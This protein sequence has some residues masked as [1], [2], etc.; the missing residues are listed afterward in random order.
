MALRQV[1]GTEDHRFHI[2]FPNTAA[3][4]TEARY[5]MVGF[6]RA[7]RLPPEFVADVEVVVGEALANAA[8]HGYRARGT[9]IIDAKLT[10]QYLEAT[11][12]DDGPGFFHRGPRPLQHPPAYSPRGYGTF[13]M[14]ALADQLEFRNDG[15]TV[16]FRM[17]VRSNA[18]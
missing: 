16:W 11:V 6:I 8:E 4:T 15:R 9:I 18:E 17:R 5:Q 3:G 2:A 14:H 7:F 13:L 1:V 12:A 10:E